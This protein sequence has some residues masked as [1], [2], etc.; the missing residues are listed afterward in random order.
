MSRS[1]DRNPSPERGAPDPARGALGARDADVN[2]KVAIVSWTDG[3]RESLARRVFMTTLGADL[4]RVAPGEVD[5]AL[6][7][8]AAL[9]QQ[10]GSLHAGAISSIADSANGYAALTPFP[11][12]TDVLTAEFKINLLAPAK[13]PRILARSRTRPALREDVLG[14]PRARRHSPRGSCRPWHWCSR[15]GPI[16]S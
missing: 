13:S 6:P 1:P 15:F 16:T 10:N 9:C 8:P 7:Y 2:G 5:I 12:G 4:V 11:P 14:L 3:A